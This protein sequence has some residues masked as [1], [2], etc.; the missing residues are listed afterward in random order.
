MSIENKKSNRRFAKGTSGNASGRPPGSRNK[1]TL[2]LE[3]LL[4]G[5]AKQL[6]SKAIELAL[7]GDMQ[8]LRLC[9]ERL[10]PPRKDRL[11]HF[12]L[13][14]VTCPEDLPLQTAAILDAISH[15]QLT[16]LEG[17]QISRIVASQVSLLAIPDL[18]RSIEKLA[19]PEEDPSLTPT[20]DKV[21]FLTN[22]K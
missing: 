1:V 5:Q 20:P 2:L 22:Y 21:T 15:G 14:P 12:D 13:P 19:H 3:E 9:L 8:A 4:E 16:P 11:V 17:E 18:Q 7:A 6:T 10:V